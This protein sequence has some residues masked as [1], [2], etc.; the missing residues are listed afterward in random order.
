MDPEKDK[1]IQFI[2]SVH[3][4][5]QQQADEIVS[6]FKEKEF[7]KND[8]L[9]KEGRVCNEYHILEEGFARAYTYDLEG[10]DVTTAFYSTNQ[11]V[12]ELFS[13]FKRIP[14]REYIQ[15]LSDCKSWYITYEELQIVFHSMPQFREFGRSILV[16][17]Y[18]SLKQRMLS[19]LHETAEDRYSN[20]IKSNP[21]IFQYAPLKN[22]ASF[23]GVTDTSL[24]RIRKEFAKNQTDH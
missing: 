15:A 19:T 10:T 5:P 4:M 16:N 21:D 24:S 9:L 17:A 12:C 20:L 22:I 6:F 2:L 11:V 13:F 1:L 23:V 14:S 18:A 3:S 8:F 7:S